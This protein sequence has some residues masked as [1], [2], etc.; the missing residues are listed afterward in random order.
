ML[1]NQTTHWNGHISM[2]NVYYKIK[3]KIGDIPILDLMYAKWHGPDIGWSF[4]STSWNPSQ[5]NKVLKEDSDSK[6]V[7]DVIDLPDLLSEIP[8]WTPSMKN[9]KSPSDFI[10]GRKILNT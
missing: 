1:E 4:P 8:G 3:I 6:F 2:P 5:F 7:I 9:K 10:R